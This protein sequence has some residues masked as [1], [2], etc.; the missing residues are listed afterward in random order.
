MLLNLAGGLTGGD[1]LEFGAGPDEGSSV[2]ISTQACERIY[3]SRGEDPAKASP[4]ENS[5]IIG[6]ECQAKTKRRSS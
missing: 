4:K 1:R 6:M 2:V 5:I 3:R